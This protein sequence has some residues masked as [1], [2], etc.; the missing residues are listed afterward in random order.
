LGGAIFSLP[1][2][3]LSAE[4]EPVSLCSI[5]SRAEK[6]IYGRELPALLPRRALP[7]RLFA[8][9]PAPTLLHLPVLFSGGAFRLPLFLVLRARP[10]AASR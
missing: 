2:R 3:L 1:F 6:F 5:F 7:H 4:G 9:L 8:R 10:P